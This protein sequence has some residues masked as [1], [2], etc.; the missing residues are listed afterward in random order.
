M[1][2]PM[3][4]TARQRALLEKRSLD[5]VEDALSIIPAEPLMALPSGTFFYNF[6]LFTHLNISI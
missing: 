1:K 4:M 3:L 2:N 6:W 5:G